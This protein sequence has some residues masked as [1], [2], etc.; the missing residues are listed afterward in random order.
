VHLASP[1]GEPTATPIAEPFDASS[2]DRVLRELADPV[3]GC[4]IANGSL[5]VDADDV[6]FSCYEMHEEQQLFGGGSLSA[7]LRSSI[8]VSFLV[9]PAYAACL[10]DPDDVKPPNVVEHLRDVVANQTNL[11]VLTARGALVAT[12]GTPV[13]AGDTAT[14]STAQLCNVVF[15]SGVFYPLRR[16]G[17]AAYTRSAA[18]GGSATWA[19]V[20]PEDQFL[21]GRH[22]GSGN[23]IDLHILPT[24]VAGGT[25]V[26]NK[27][28]SHATLP[29][30]P[31]GA[32]IVG[33]LTQVL[34]MKRIFHPGV[35]G[36]G[37]V[38]ERRYEARVAGYPTAK[39]LVDN[40]VQT[41]VS[42]AMETFLVETFDRQSEYTFVQYLEQLTGYTANFFVRFVWWWPVCRLGPAAGLAVGRCATA[43]RASA[44]ASGAGARGSQC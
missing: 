43:A 11:D 15:F 25:P 22:V 18:T 44:N 40:Y 32:A 26:Q 35:Q 13:T 21:V 36:P 6:C 42:I 30:I 16:G 8:D 9:Y 12:D 4:S 19:R 34:L 29:G 24:V 14:L 23:A 10:A 39:P 3:D 27:A 1:P 28:I 7:N 17:G 37:S 38:E 20:G 2:S 31:V 41:E 33:R 5:S